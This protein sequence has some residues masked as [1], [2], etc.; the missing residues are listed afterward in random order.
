MEKEILWIV[1]D[2]GSNIQDPNDTFGSWGYIMLKESGEGLELVNKDT[3]YLTGTTTPRMEFT[4]VLESLK[5]LSGMNPEKCDVYFIVDAD[6]TRLTLEQ[7]Y[8]KWRRNA[9]AGIWYRNKKDK[10]L[11]QDLIEPIVTL[12]EV[13][14]RKN[15]VKFMHIRSHVKDDEKNAAYQKFMTTN[16]VAISYNTFNILLKLNDTVDKMC[17]ETMKRGRANGN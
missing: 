17:T 2:G 6:N 13:M 12:V 16:G 9:V 1:A 4:A 7:W 11:N 8:V 15:Y 10:V 14:K 3:R 5:Y